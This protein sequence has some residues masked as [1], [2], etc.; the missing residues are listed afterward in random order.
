MEISRASLRKTLCGQGGGRDGGKARKR[1]LLMLRIKRPG[2]C[3]AVI[4]LLAFGLSL[5][6]ASSAHCQF[7]FGMSGIGGSVGTE[8]ADSENSRTPFTVK[9]TGVLNPTTPKPESLAVLEMTVGNFGEHYHFEVQAIEFPDAPQASP[10]QLLQSLKKYK[11]QMIAVGDK[12]TLTKLG[13]AFPNSPL[14]VVGLFRRRYR[15]FQVTDVEVFRLGGL[16][17]PLADKFPSPL[18]AAE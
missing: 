13:Q 5:W 17:E 11:V 2:F 3:R 7:G 9:L 10:T 4:L 1:I 18:P 8:G 16:P 12:Q 15:T 6:P 14:S